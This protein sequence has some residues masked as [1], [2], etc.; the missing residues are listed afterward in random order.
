MPH[1]NDECQACYHERRLH[2]DHGC[3]YEID[4]QVQEVGPVAHR[5]ICEQFIEE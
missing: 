3:E 5:C 2:D 1:D 4:V